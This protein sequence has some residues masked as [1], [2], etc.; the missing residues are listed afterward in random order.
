MWSRGRDGGE[1]AKGSRP[2]V[3]HAETVNGV[4]PRTLSGASRVLSLWSG[5]FSDDAPLCGD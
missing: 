3:R 2:K 5:L 4:R 1:K